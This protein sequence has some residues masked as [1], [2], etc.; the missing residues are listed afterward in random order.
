MRFKKPECPLPT[1][2]RWIG[3]VLH[4]VPH[5]PSHWAVFAPA[6]GIFSICRQASKQQQQ[7]AVESSVLFFLFEIFDLPADRGAVECGM[8]FRRPGAR[9]SGTFSLGIQVYRTFFIRNTVVPRI[10]H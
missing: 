3:D 1:V 8:F 9:A 2:P 5:V 7:M 10:F 4:P 6:G